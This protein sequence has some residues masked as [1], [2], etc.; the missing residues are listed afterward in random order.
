MEQRQQQINEAAQKFAEA[1]K[2]S[3]EALVDSSVSA[4]EVNAQLTQGFFN[5]V[6]GN[7]MAQASDNQALAEN[8]AEQQLRQQEFVQGLV[9]ESMDAYMDFLNSMFSYYRGYKEPEEQGADTE[10]QG[11]DT[12]GR[13]GQDA[14]VFEH[15]VWKGSGQGAREEYLKVLERTGE[16]KPGSGELPADFWDLPRPD[17]LEGLMRRAVQEERR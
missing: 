13:T 4:Q 14:K 16:I 12:Q 7:L 15:T 6:I 1:I 17:D 8:L 11:A 2:E 9:Q 5:E 3:F 10:G